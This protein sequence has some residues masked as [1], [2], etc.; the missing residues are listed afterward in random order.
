MW[1]AGVKIEETLRAFNDLVRAGKVRYLGLSNLSGAQL[2][3]IVDYSKFMGLD[4]RVVLE[5]HYNLLERHSE[6]EVIPTCLAEGVALI[7]YGALKGGLL[8]GKFKREQKDVSSALPG[9]RLAWTAEKHDERSFGTTTLEDYRNND[10]YW[11][12]M[13]KMQSMAHTHGRTVTQVAIRW[14]LQKKFVSSV[15]IGA[16]NVEQLDDCMG[17]GTGWTLSD[18][19]MK[20][21]DQLSIVAE[22]VASVYPYTAIARFNYNRVRE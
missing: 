4:E 16:K 14:L 3:K 15:L 13:D 6:I 22:P 7:P 1:D 18:D 19:E 5:Q 11:A 17:A 9:S 21:L 12:L 2:Q 8:T 10:N 20:Q